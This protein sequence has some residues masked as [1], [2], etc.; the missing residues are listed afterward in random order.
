MDRGGWQATVHGGRK[1]SDTTEQLTQFIKGGSINHEEK[2][3]FI[4]SCV[5]PLDCS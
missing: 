2:E 4:H 3:L 5:H 1:V